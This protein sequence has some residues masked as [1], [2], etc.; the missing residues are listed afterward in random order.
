ML[1]LKVY[2]LILITFYFETTCLLPAH[3]QFMLDVPSQI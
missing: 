1:L 3:A 2:V